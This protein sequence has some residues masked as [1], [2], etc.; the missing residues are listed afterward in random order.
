MLIKIVNFIK[1][2]IFI[3]IFIFCMLVVVFSL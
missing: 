3:L 2:N 1:E